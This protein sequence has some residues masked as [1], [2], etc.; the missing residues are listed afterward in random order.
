MNKG[1]T[2]YTCCFHRNFEKKAGIVS[3]G[4]FYKQL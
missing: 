2:I 1:F 4:I 3:H